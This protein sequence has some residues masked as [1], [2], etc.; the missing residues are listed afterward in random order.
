[1]S[2]PT[3][4]A[5]A[6]AAAIREHGRSVRE[7]VDE[8]LSR[9]DTRDGPLNAFTFPMAER[10]RAE[11]DAADRTL[12]HHGVLPPLFGVPISVKD[13]IWLRDVP[14]TNGSLALADFVPDADCVCVARLREAGAIVVGKTNNPEFCYGGYTDNL[15]YGLTHNPWDL[16]RTPGGS[17]GGAAV[18]VAAGMVPLAL[19]SDGGGSIRIPSAFCGV[20]GH[21]P[22]FGLIPKE[23]GFRGWKTLSVDG[24]L[25]VSVRDAALA[26]SVMAGQSDADDMTHPAPVVDYTAGLGRDLSHLR[27]AYSVDLGVADVA[28]DVRRAFADAVGV[29]RR[30]SGA[31]V[32]EDHPRTPEPTPLWNSL[33]LVEGY[34]SEGPLLER[35]AGRMSSGVADIIRAGRDTAGWE[36]VDSMHRRAEFTRTWAEFFHRYDALLLPA[37]PITAFAA[38]EQRPASIDGNPVDPFFDAWCTLALP[39]N[40]TGQPSTTVP[41]GLGDDGM[42]VA[43]QVMARRFGDATSLSLAAAFEAEMPRRHPASGP[44]VG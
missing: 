19:G 18:S 37:M 22:T 30:V 23:P 44:A 16:D 5:T 29:V 14:A 28:P 9:I 21:K 41:M 10:A 25:A 12:R 43:L 20:V 38:G 36:Y 33:A 24:P 17:S 6:T 42:P 35:W 27:V 7:V 2:V 1:M 32:V 26:V 15:V 11:A 34:A 40:L 31:T 4:D 3:D 13:H 39:A 8:A